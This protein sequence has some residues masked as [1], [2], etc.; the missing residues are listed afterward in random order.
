LRDEN[1]PIPL[2]HIFG[3]LDSRDG[4]KIEPY[5]RNVWAVRISTEQYEK[6]KKLFKN[7]FFSEKL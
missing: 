6:L 2:G 1:K 4:I 3:K 5:L 7:R